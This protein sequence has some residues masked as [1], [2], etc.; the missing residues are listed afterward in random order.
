MRFFS[1]CK[2]EEERKQLYR[3]LSKLFHPDHGGDAEMMT[4]LNKQYNNP[5]SSFSEEF[6]PKSNFKHP[7]GNATSHEHANTAPNYEALKRA[8]ALNIELHER[9]ASQSSKIRDL[10]AVIDEKDNKLKAL[11]EDRD[12]ILKD[13][14]MTKE[15][16]NNEKTALIFFFMVASPIL[17]FNLFRWLWG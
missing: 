3:K 13:L 5:I 15:D 10:Y 17:L 14:A 16:N 12:E 1:D 4:E 11:T 9:I 7:F 6:K 8:N 2:S